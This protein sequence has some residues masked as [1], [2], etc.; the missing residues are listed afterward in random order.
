MLA[1]YPWAANAS[2]VARRPP[3]PSPRGPG[4]WCLYCIRAVRRQ[5]YL[6]LTFGG[7]DASG[8]RVAVPIPQGPQTQSFSPAVDPFL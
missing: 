7:L 6:W 8:F 3:V 1:G 2:Q 4:P 5:C